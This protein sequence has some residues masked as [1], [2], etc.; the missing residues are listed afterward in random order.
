MTGELIPGS[1]V[2]QAGS[3]WKETRLLRTVFPAGLHDGRSWEHG[4]FVGAAGG[5]TG[6]K[7]GTK[8]SKQA[9]RPTPR[10]LPDPGAGAAKARARKR[11]ALQ[12]LWAP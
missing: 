7:D 9:L 5:R 12:P 6:R 1:E 2:P 8:R 10:P 11:W 3:R 4:T